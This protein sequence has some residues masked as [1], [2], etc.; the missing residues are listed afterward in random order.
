MKLLYNFVSLFTDL[1]QQSL[2]CYADDR[3][4]AQWCCQTYVAI[5]LLM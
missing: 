3:L 5:C 1:N 2:T 4:H